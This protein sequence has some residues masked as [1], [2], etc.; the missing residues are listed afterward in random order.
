M[1]AKDLRGAEEAWKRALDRD[2]THGDTLLSLAKFYQK[3]GAYK[4]AAPLLDLLWSTHPE[5][6]KGYYPHGVNLYYQG[7]YEESLEALDRSRFFSEPFVH[8]YQSLTLKKLGREEEAKRALGQFIASLDET[9]KELE[10]QP[11][12][13]KKL[14]YRAR[15]AWRR[16]IGILI[17]EEERMAQIFERVVS[18]PL[19]RLYGGAG[20]FILGRFE[21]AAVVLEKGIEELG[22]VAPG[23]VTYYYL[24]LTYKELGRTKEAEAAMEAFIQN[25]IFDPDDLRVLEAKRTLERLKQTRGRDA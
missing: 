10:T 4:K 12:K 23:S 15:V 6:I 11:K 3:Q 1:K 24:G 25:H 2:P 18:R 14:A 20:L 22:R 7:K 8:Y 19:S 21:D 16:E 9:R 5:I 17:P 13:Y